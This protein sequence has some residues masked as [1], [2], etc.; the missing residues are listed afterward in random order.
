VR[1]VLP[2]E[3]LDYGMLYDG[4][5]RAHPVIFVFEPVY[6]KVLIE[7]CAFHKQGTTNPHE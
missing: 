5:L 6:P 1:A 2:A 7:H 4:L 3:H